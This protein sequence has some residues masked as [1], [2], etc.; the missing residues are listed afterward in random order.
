ME[1]DSDMNCREEK[2]L[3]IFKEPLS[4]ADSSEHDESR[5]KPEILFISWFLSRVSKT[6]TKGHMLIRVHNYLLPS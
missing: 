3:D 4:A 1:S 6:H 5:T 2:D